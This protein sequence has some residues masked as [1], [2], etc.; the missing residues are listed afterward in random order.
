[1]QC[2][3]VLGKASQNEPEIQCCSEP[4]GVWLADVEAYGV[5]YGLRSIHRLPLILAEGRLRLHHPQVTL[6]V[7]AHRSSYSL[8][9]TMLVQLKSTTVALDVYGGYRRAGSDEHSEAVWVL[10][11]ETM[12]GRV[13][14]KPLDM[15]VFSVQHT[16]L[17]LCNLTARGLQHLQLQATTQLAVGEGCS[18]P[19]TLDFVASSTLGSADW[20]FQA[21]LAAEDD[22]A[23]PTAANGVTLAAVLTGVLRATQREHQQQ[24]GRIKVEEEE[25]EDRSYVPPDFTHE[26][27]VRRLD[28]AR[29]YLSG[30]EGTTGSEG[31]GWH[32]SG[33]ADVSPEVELDIAMR[34][35]ERRALNGAA[36]A[37]FRSAADHPN[38]FPFHV[39]VPDST[40]EAVRVQLRYADDTAL[41]LEAG[42][43]LAQMAYSATFDRQ[44]SPHVRGIGLQATLQ[45]QLDG[46]NVS[47]TASGEYTARTG[48]WRLVA[49][50][51]VL[52][53]QAALGVEWM[54]MD[55]IRVEMVVDTEGT[56]RYDVTGNGT[57]QFLQGCTPLP[58][59]AHAAAALN[60]DGRLQPPTQWIVRAGLNATGLCAESESKGE[61]MSLRTAM[62]TLGR[63]VRRDNG[64]EPPVAL[65]AL[66][67]DQL[68]V[69]FTTAE[70]RGCDPPSLCLAHGAAD[71]AAGV[72]S[73]GWALRGV[74]RLLGD[75]GDELLVGQP[76]QSQIID[77][78][79]GRE[80]VAEGNSKVVEFNLLIP[81][82]EQSERP[83][84]LGYRA[85]Q[86]P[87]V[88]LADTS[89]GNAGAVMA[90]GIEGDALTDPMMEFP[91]LRAEFAGVV[92]A[93]PGSPLNVKGAARWVDGAW[94]ITDASLL[95]AAWE[96]P[97]GLRFVKATHVTAASGVITGVDT[98]RQQLQALNISTTVQLTL[99]DGGGCTPAAGVLTVA[100]RERLTLTDWCLQTDD[101]L[102][103]CVTATEDSAAMNSA[104]G[105]GAVM[106][107]DLMQQIVETT[108]DAPPEA[109][110]PLLVGVP[111]ERIS[112]VARTSPVCEHDESDTGSGWT[113]EGVLVLDRQQEDS[114]ALAQAMGALQGTAE[115]RPGPGSSSPKMQLGRF[116]FTL[117]LPLHPTDARMRL[118][119]R[120][121]E[122]QTSVQL[123]QRHL[124]LEQTVFTAALG[125]QG[126]DGENATLSLYSHVRAVLGP[127]EL[128]F[129]VSGA[130]DSERAVWVLRGAMHQDWRVPLEV[131]VL[132][133]DPRSQHDFRGE[134]DSGGV[135]SL[136]VDM[137][138][139]VALAPG[140]VVESAA[141]SLALGG[142]AFEDKSLRWCLRAEQQA[143]CSLQAAATD[144]QA[145]ST[146]TAAAVGVPLTAVFDRVRGD[147]SA[148]H[149]SPPLLAEL[150]VQAIGPLRFETPGCTLAGEDEG[151]NDGVK[152]SNHSMGGWTIEGVGSVIAGGVVDAALA[153][154]E[155]SWTLSADAAASTSTRTGKYRFALHMPEASHAGMISGGS[156]VAAHAR[157]GVGFAEDV[158]LSMEQGRLVMHGAMLETTLDPAV[159]ERTWQLQATMEAALHGSSARFSA[160]AALDSVRDSWVVSGA[161]LSEPWERPLGMSFLHV[162]DAHATTRIDAAAG[163]VQAME[164]V[165]TATVAMDLPAGATCEFAA[166][167]AVATSPHMADTLW[168]VDGTLLAAHNCTL[169]SES[170]FASLGGVIRRMHASLERDL[171]KPSVLDEMRVQWVRLQRVNSPQRCAVTGVAAA[172]ACCVTP[173]GAKQRDGAHLV[174]GL[175]LSGAVT[176][177]EGSFPGADTL[178]HLLEVLGGAS[179]TTSGLEFVLEIPDDDDATDAE[180]RRRPV[181]S[182]RVPGGVRWPLEFLQGRL[183]LRDGSLEV[184]D[185]ANVTTDELRLLGTLET[186]LLGS[187]L[188]PVHVRGAYSKHGRADHWML[189]GAVAD[190]E[191]AGTW[192][193]APVSGLRVTAVNVSAGISAEETQLVVHAEG[194][195]SL[196]AATATAERC[197]M[198]TH[199]SAHAVHPIDAEWCLDARG[200]TDVLSKCAALMM[201]PLFVQLLTSPEDAPAPAAASITRTETGAGG[202]VVAPAAP[203]QRPRMVEE[204][205][206]AAVS[207][208]LGGLTVTELSVSH[209]SSATCFHNDHWRE[210]HTTDAVRPQRLGWTAVGSLRAAADSAVAKWLQP[211][212]LW[213][214]AA[215]AAAVRP[216]HLHVHAPEQRAALGGAGRLVVGVTEAPGALVSLSDDG[217]VQLLNASLGL[218][219]NDAWADA[220]KAALAGVL[221]VRV[222]P[223]CSV[224]FF[225][226]GS[227]SGAGGWELTGSLLRNN[228]ELT[229]LDVEVDPSTPREP[230]PTT[231]AALKGAT[232][233]KA[234][235]VV[236]EELQ[237]QGLELA[238]KVDLQLGGDCEAEAAADFILHMGRAQAA[239]AANRLGG[240]VWHAN[241][242]FPATCLL[243]MVETGLGADAGR[244]HQLLQAVVVKSATVQVTLTGGGGGGGDASLETWHGQPLR[245]G[246]QVH[247]TE[248]TLGVGSAARNLFVALVGWK[249]RA[250]LLSRLSR[251]KPQM[252]VRAVEVRA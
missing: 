134:V 133:V 127:R 80:D 232:A 249:V 39:W 148:S 73:P 23:G 107:G 71:G 165:G 81:A 225:L 100:S 229:V 209:A 98:A 124:K 162:H 211:L 132:V 56:R 178:E 13:W 158:P 131:D 180:G 12:Q 28:A 241:T 248:A 176:M 19:A 108:T 150:T 16:R 21:S 245:R 77:V 206:A 110:S 52:P 43:V 250:T 188:P 227:R 145:S 102:V 3:T 78:P 154:F 177:P 120:H 79:G 221:R 244:A 214:D 139:S 203:T 236:G 173:R 30:C 193:P 2:V 55:A 141:L 200:A 92:G 138:A 33:V 239:S 104:V 97:L 205:E 185:T 196:A 105:S 87:Q 93:Q 4:T 197:E 88:V 26:V 41:H 84:I 45:V 183:R 179:S 123:A 219:V 114:V 142:K 83:A 189:T 184:S 50:S 82:T 112:R 201:A 103:D 63:A 243:G 90:V 38:S 36:A 1:V 153:S 74:G 57:L 35:L 5:S 195:L 167:L 140:C 238:A 62:R 122:P 175:L 46:H 119:F 191:S 51:E 34:Q 216:F 94:Q 149:S 24:A 157:L 217:T 233:A 226:M 147:N 106:L 58:T 194:A 144:E 246:A 118:S 64:Y 31:R 198:P 192:A 17:V 70:W 116:N 213:D 91:S 7:D 29:P 126:Q 174:N 164:A 65:D 27:L 234:R 125:V 128:Q 99:S 146:T 42:V 76:V 9:A 220:A 72:V 136:E 67:T 215:D 60:A 204:A 242:S 161:P 143:P 172:A 68:T 170:A 231:L 228:S 152:G 235:L 59:R 121:T 40:E 54:T 155:R 212:V 129:P 69:Q 210:D 101:R 252:A 111:V 86:P 48:E 11:G 159:Q 137:R 6:H 168:C 156:N 47:L 44:G 247:V 207:A 61:L 151:A 10:E 182:F 181:L 163:G 230:L 169:D 96:A 240:M 25:E 218:D 222:A 8:H 190:P 117:R 49:H 223:D 20:C 171:A 224:E 22:C 85:L 53:W 130:Y 95:A 75:R 15:D 14:D 37:A 251:K 199:L 135:R 109:P 66:V 113:V 160:V 237:R 187:S 186:D 202:Q 115:T 166:S 208:A 32:L 18:L 89:P